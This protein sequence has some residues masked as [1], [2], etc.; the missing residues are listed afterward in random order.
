V[1]QAPGEGEAMCAALNAGGLVDACATFDGDVLLFGAH[2]VYHT[3]K[4]QV[5]CSSPFWQTLLISTAKRL[6]GVHLARLMLQLSSRNAVARQLVSSIEMQ[7]TIN[8][9]VMTQL[10][11]RRLVDVLFDALRSTH[12]C[13]SYLHD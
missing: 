12:T 13:V 4:L 10:P 11:R 5:I 3:L 6:V 8:W 2:T 9:I 7:R 1:V